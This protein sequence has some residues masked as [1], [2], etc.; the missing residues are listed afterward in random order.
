MRHARWTTCGSDRIKLGAR[1]AQL[2][3]ALS[4]PGRVSDKSRLW[5]WSHRDVPLRCSA[6]IPGCSASLHSLSDVISI[7]VRIVPTESGGV[8]NMSWPSSQHFGHGFDWGIVHGRRSFSRRLDPK[9]GAQGLGLDVIPPFWLR[10]G[11]HRCPN[12]I[13]QVAPGGRKSTLRPKSETD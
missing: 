10:F 9:T 2:R 6:S 13:L 7:P 12:E 8:F 11:P 5:W 3:M 1:S 4:A